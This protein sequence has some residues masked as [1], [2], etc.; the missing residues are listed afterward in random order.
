[1][2]QTTSTPVIRWTSAPTLLNSIFL[3][4]DD[5][6]CA[7]KH[8]DSKRNN[9]GD[10][11][12]L[13]ESMKSR[14]AKPAVFGPAE[15]VAALRARG[16]SATIETASQN[17]DQL[18][19]IDP[20]GFLKCVDG[21]GSDAEGKQQHGPKMLGGVYGIANNRGIQTSE[22]LKAICQEVKDAGYVPT[23]HGDDRSGM[24]GCGFCK[25]WL[26]GSFAGISADKPEFDADQGA[27]AVKGA[28]GVNEMHAG[29]HSEKVVY[30]N[31][32]ADKT[33]VPNGD[34]QR[35]I[36]DAWAAVKF[37][38]DVPKY[39]VTAAATVE[40]LGGPKEAIVIVPDGDPD[41]SETCY[42]CGADLWEAELS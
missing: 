27:R 3:R 20:A 40:M 10:G 35:F 41:T 23:C 34:D 36:V 11:V 19:D 38:L 18:V 25:L 17:A 15:V 22:E 26:N 42:P 33:L 2:G 13:P 28:G 31:F 32:V 21:R 24:L 14:E 4:K 29:A 12:D 9:V 16:W 39:C 1:M 5:G 7:E 37:N 30:L 8:I 6:E